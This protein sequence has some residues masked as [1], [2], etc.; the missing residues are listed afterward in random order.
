MFKKG[1]LKFL[2]L[3]LFAGVVYGEGESCQELGSILRGEASKTDKICD[4]FVP[5]NNIVSTL[6]GFVLQPGI[7]IGLEVTV[8]P[9]KGSQKKAFDG[10]IALL[11]NEIQETS[12][13]LK[14]HGFNIIA[15][16]NHY[17]EETPKIMFLHFEKQGNPLKIAQQLRQ[18]ADMIG[19][20]DSSTFP[21]TSSL[22]PN[23]I[24]SILKLNGGIK[25]NGVYR[26]DF[27]RPF[28][29]DDNGAISEPECMIA[30]E[31]TMNNALIVGEIAV[32]VNE[33]QR[34]IKALLANGLLLT[35]VHN[36]EVSETPRVYY[37]HFE[38]F[39]LPAT[40]LAQAARNAL[41]TIHVEKE[42]Q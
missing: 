11:E 36:H 7:G 14:N 1:L 32:K 21:F 27:Q 26:A 22:D 23:A 34:F 24:N 16:H 19:G 25:Q 3:L 12:I 6:N 33:M 28:K 13:F 5:R 39:G 35:A 8:I 15:L 29:I 30:I 4:I 18:L 37:I 2:F 31:G 20:F 41:N 17:L 38:Q 10:E 42:G 40:V 9:I